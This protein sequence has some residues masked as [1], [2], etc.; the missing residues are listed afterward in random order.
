MKRGF[1]NST[2]PTV[3]GDGLR[4]DYAVAVDNKRLLI[5]PPEMIVAIARVNEFILLLAASNQTNL[6]LVFKRWSRGLNHGRWYDALAVDVRFRLV[7]SSRAPAMIRTR[8]H[9]KNQLTAGHQI[10]VQQ[11]RLVVRLA[12]Q[13][14]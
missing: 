2:S 1:C 6:E 11:K 12:V 10:V 14:R 8:P 3:C 13:R 7:A 9:L 5:Y 4:L